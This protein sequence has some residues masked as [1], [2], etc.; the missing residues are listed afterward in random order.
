MYSLG[1]WVKQLAVWVP[2]CC[3][4]SVSVF[5][6]SRAWRAAT[7]CVL[8]FEAAAW[9]YRGHGPLLQVLGRT[10]V[11]WYRGHGPL[12]QVVGRN[13]VGVRGFFLGLCGLTTAAVARGHGPRY[14]GQRW[15]IAS[16]R[17]TALRVTSR[18][19]LQ[20]LPALTRVGHHPSHIRSPRV[21]RCRHTTPCPASH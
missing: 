8:S 16:Y 18:C 10:F 19:S 11:G 20:A 5:A 4:G 17:I 6:V 14:P 15:F 21:W 13:I 2:F 3:A 7:G 1:D 9:G 12:L